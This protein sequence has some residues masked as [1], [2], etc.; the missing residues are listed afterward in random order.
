MTAKSWCEL[1]E[2]EIAISL[3]SSRG[4]E[5]RGRDPLPSRAEMR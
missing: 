5:K 1:V 4:S 3:L 2:V